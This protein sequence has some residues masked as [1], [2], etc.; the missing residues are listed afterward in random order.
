MKRFR[1]MRCGEQ[2]F[3]SGFSNPYLCRNCETDLVIEG[4]NLY[5]AL[6]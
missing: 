6:E 3:K 5:E 1:C 4:G 2:I